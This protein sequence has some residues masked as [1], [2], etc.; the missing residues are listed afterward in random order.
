MGV[1]ARQLRE[2]GLPKERSSES[3]KN[4]EENPLKCEARHDRDGL[5]GGLRR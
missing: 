4:S 3:K 5:I 1:G 2:N